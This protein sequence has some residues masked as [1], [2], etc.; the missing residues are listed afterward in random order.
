MQSEVITGRI[1]IIGAM[2][3]EI[4]G[5]VAK[6][7]DTKTHTVSGVK[8][9]EGKLAGRD[10]VVAVCGVGKVF[11]AICAEAMILRFGVG[12]LLN[13]GVAGGLLP[14]LEV[15]DV[16][17]ADAVVQHDM[18]T[19]ALGDAPGLLSGIN[20]VKIPT[21]PRLLKPLCEAV[22]ELEINSV[23]GTIASGDLFVA[24]EKTKATIVERF[25][26]IA[27]EMEGAAI[28]HVAFVNNVPFAVIRAIS[29]GGDGM[30]FSKFVTLAAEQSIAVTEAFLQKL[31][32][33]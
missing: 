13:T 28:G 18:N 17:L 7:T 22:A 11:A 16:A 9:T 26:A 24:E 1:G 5:L 10:V 3:I 31:S 2:Q 23:V 21:D 8:F 6:M 27:C 32:A 19:T 20:V 30:E 25:D 4:D 33:T 29:D 15:G 14:L 12:A